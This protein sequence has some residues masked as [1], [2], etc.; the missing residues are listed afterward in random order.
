MGLRASFPTTHTDFSCGGEHWQFQWSAD[1]FCQKL[2]WLTCYCWIYRKQEKCKIYSM[3][4]YFIETDTFHCHWS[5]DWFWE[6]VVLGPSSIFINFCNDV[7]LINFPVNYLL[8]DHSSVILYFNYTTRTSM[9]TLSIFW[10]THFD[11]IKISAKY[12][13]GSN[14]NARTCLIRDYLKWTADLYALEKLSLIPTF[15]V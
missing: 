15:T 12:S 11:E 2:T 14:L 1:I 10:F 6:R 7:V 4:C 3:E 13:K 5:F 9:L 8:L